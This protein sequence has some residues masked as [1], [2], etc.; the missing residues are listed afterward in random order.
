MPLHIQI[1]LSLLLTFPLLLAYKSIN[2]SILFSP[3]LLGQ[4]SFVISF[5]TVISLSSAGSIPEHVAYVISA[6]FLFFYVIFLYLPYLIKNRWNV[7]IKTLHITSFDKRAARIFT[8]VTVFIMLFYFLR[9]LEY[10]TGDERLLLNRNMRWLSI[11]QMIFLSWTTIIVSLIYARL[12]EREFLLYVIMMIVLSF[13]TGSKSAALS[14]FFVA[15]FFYTNITRFSF[16][17]VNLSLVIFISL[18]VLPTFLYYGDGAILILLHRIIMSGDIYQ[19]SFV[20]GDY[21][22][23]QG[24]YDPFR[25]LLHPFSAIV[26][27]R[28]YDYPLGAEILSTARIP[29]SGTGPNPQLPILSLVLFNSISSI[30]AFV[31]FTAFLLIFFVW[32]AAYFLNSRKFHLFF[33]IYVFMTIY[34]S[35]TAIFLDF[36]FF[37]FQVIGMVIAF[38]AYLAVLCLRNTRYLRPRGA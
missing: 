7:F 15:M 16:K 19:L 11:L 23:L 6:F 1:I 35:T 31:V 37:Q 28:G 25:Y 22:M 13:L 38:C 10:N 32:F 18:L 34:T 24:Y 20:T 29:V 21:S 2:G 27:I 9:L 14:N 3:L 17:T 33:R 8:F 5:I 36:G 12:K 30:F 4:A 26:G